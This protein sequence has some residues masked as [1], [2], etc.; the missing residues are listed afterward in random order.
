MSVKT[1]VLLG[2]S[3]F[4]LMPFVANAAGTYYNYNGTI[5]RN[6]GG[7]YA[8]V[9]ENYGG[10][11]GGYG[12]GAGART[13]MNSNPYAVNN[14]TSFGRYGDG[15]TSANTSAQQNVTKIPALPRSSGV[16]GGLTDG[17]FSLGAGF[18]H[19]FAAWNFDMNTAGSKLHY[20]NIR[21]NV[22]DANAK[23]DFYVKNTAL[24]LDVGGQ[25]GTQY[26]ESSMVDDDI[27]NG[28][29]FSQYW[30]VDLNGDAVADQVWTQQGHALSVGTSED[31]S[32]MGVYAGL[33]VKDAFRFG[34]FRVTPSI[35]YRYFKYKLDTKRNYGMS[36]DIV[37]GAS[38]Y[39][40][41]SGGETQCLPFLVFVDSN[42]NPLLGIIEGVDLNGDSIIDTLS[43]VSIPSGAQY[44]E[45]ED[46]YY[47]YQD[48]VSHS[49]EVEWSGPYVA[50]DI[51]YDISLNDSVMARLELG[52]P[53]YTATA[54]QP[55]RPDWQH[56]KS[57]EDTADIGDAYHFGFGANW[58]HSLT[59]S[60]MLTV[61]VT[62]DYYNVGKAQAASYLNPDYYN[63]MYY[64]PAVD[65]NNALAS[66]EYYGSA[67][68]ADWTQ[69]RADALGR[70]LNVDKA[71]YRSNLE[72]IDAI[73]DLKSKGWKET[74]AD[75]IESLYRSIGVRI[76]LQAK[77]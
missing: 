73:N 5:Q 22:F 10:C 42:N 11:T 47:Y 61:G 4:A 41:S 48:G 36:L 53:A 21:W 32:M 58:L 74:V 35:G 30:N 66:S 38:N 45:T 69:A 54:D 65:T 62:F 68:V 16:R 3:I 71:V 37:E 52:L 20:D 55:Y 15:D 1:R 39:C 2:C 14:D 18:V 34:G 67:N 57:L 46:S 31:G 50:L 23:Y 56:P 7:P 60:I 77:F 12:C 43:Y 17:G 76:G 49:Y 75:E 40:Q 25:Y 8:N 26:G 33:G 28:G 44:V 9:I 6:Y 72:T 19:Q 29:F 24:R 27:T 13:T 64:N 51:N 63:T 59:D 70:D